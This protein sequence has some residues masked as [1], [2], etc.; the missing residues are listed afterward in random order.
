[1]RATLWLVGLFAIAVALALFAGN[2]PGTVTLFWPPHRVDISLNLFLLVIALVFI[3]L[4]LA[5]RTLVA[6]FGI[7]QQARRWRLQQRERAIQSALL[8]SFSHWVGGRFIRARKAAEL[9]VSLEQSVAH[10][11][12]S[13]SYAERLRTLAHLLAAESAHALQDRALREMHFR[14]ALEHSQAR[15]A[16]EMR[17]GVQLRAA[18]W[19]LDDRDAAKSMEWLDLMPQGAS[20]RTLAL[21]LR[22]KAAR[23]AGRPQ[24]AL[25]MARLLTKHRAF[26]EVAGKSIAR[27]LAIELI[28]AAHDPVQLQRAWDSLE[29]AEREL[30][31]VAM[32]AAQRL[33]DQGGEAQTSRQWLLPVWN[34]LMEQADALNLGQKVHLVRVLEA[35]F[36]P[37]GQAP[38]AQWL[39]RIESA[40]IANPRD[41]ALQYLAGVV[42]M[43][44]A[45]WGKAQQMLK[46]S[47]ALLQDSGLKRDAWRAL[48]EMAEQRQDA[49]GATQA[50]RQALLE[51]SRR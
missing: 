25:E 47:L 10:S 29:H 30:P 45:L 13:M 6:F 21:R 27:G 17:D 20:R 8:D 33:L 2:D 7:P 5:L 41:A 39:A 18:R 37:H 34:R 14:Q 35:G 16:Q 24:Q 28:N 12:E 36:G 43:R 23:M 49:A 40:Q 42:C 19:A 32:Q 51:A 22:F 44:L 38:D 31:D 46:Q 26:S 11:G 4:H 9:V 15:D 50:Y 48:A 3:V 1:V